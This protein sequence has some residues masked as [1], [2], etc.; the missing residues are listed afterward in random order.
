MGIL[1][2]MPKKILKQLLADFQKRN[3]STED[4]HQGYEGMLLG[5]LQHNYYSN[6]APATIDFGTAFSILER[7]GL[8]RTGPLVPYNNFPGV[9]LPVIGTGVRKREYVYL[10]EAGYKAARSLS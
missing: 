7:D 10:T 2:D 3:L 8:V 4:L 1:E 6:D 5:T 9:P